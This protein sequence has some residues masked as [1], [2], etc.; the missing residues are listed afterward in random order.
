MAVI[1][2]AL[3]RSRGVKESETGERIFTNSSDESKEV[4]RDRLVDK[5][6]SQ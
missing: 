1:A 3:I 5:S 4:L 2:V 6:V